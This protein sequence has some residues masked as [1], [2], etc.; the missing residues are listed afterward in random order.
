MEDRKKEERK[1]KAKRGKERKKGLPRCIDKERKSGSRMVLLLQALECNLDILEQWC[2]RGAKE[3][4][5]LDDLQFDLET[6]T[7]LAMEKRRRQ[8]NT[9]RVNVS[10]CIHSNQV[11]D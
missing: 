1:A 11:E 4:N 9:G 3:K 7:R 8:R 10:S 6:S 2:E 5:D